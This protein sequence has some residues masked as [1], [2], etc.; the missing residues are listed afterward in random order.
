VAFPRAGARAESGDRP[1]AT[2]P[3]EEKDRIRRE[4]PGDVDVALRHLVSRPGVWRDVLGVGGAGS[5]GVDQGVEAARR[6]SAEVKSLALLSG[7]TLQPG[8]QFLRQATQLPELFVVAA[9]DEYPPTVEAMELLY[10][11]S[12]SPAKKLVHYSASA[13]APWIWYETFDAGRV[14]AQGGHGTDLFNVHPEL[15]GIVVDWFVTTLIKTPGHAPADTL[16]AAPLLDQIR[17]PGGVAQVRRQLMAARRR[18]REAELFPEITVSIIGQDHLRAGEPKAAVEVFELLLLAYPDSA[19]AHES[20]PC[21]RPACRRSPSCARSPPARR[22]CWAGRTAL[23]P[24]SP[25][26]SQTSSPWPATRSPTSPSSS[27]SAS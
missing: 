19:D 2:L 15:P 22:R 6:H 5:F 13:D 4:W 3:S 20:P 26:S 27:A 11:T 14:P 16:A 9:D 12:S 23:A 21:A 17:R 10:V 24:S 8:L 1:F 18:D 7:E 25:A